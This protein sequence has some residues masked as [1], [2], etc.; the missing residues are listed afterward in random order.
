MF[1]R[2]PPATQALLIAN[3]VVFMLQ[4]FLAPA[5]TDLFVMWPVN[6]AA[7][8]AGYGFQPWQ[9][10]TS[11]FMHG[12]FGHLF[13]NMLALWIFGSPLEQ[14]WGERRYLVYYF[15]CLIGANLCQLLA[16]S[17]FTAET[18]RLYSSLGASG[19]VFGLLLGFGMLFPNRRMIIFPFPVEITARTLVI[20]YAVATLLFGITGWQPGVGHFAHLGGM[21]FGWLLIRY[22]RGQPP[23][24]KRR[25][26]PPRMRIVK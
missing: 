1:P 23:F 21:L 11:G 2:L 22:W 10:L 20:I 24:G 5:I 19:G 13:F 3:G 18:G 7:A 16:I 9:L 25:P 26:P 6:D 17:W 14:T 4:V 12:G 15:V 8:A